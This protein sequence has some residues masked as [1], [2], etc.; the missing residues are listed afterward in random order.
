MLLTG[1][2]RSV[3]ARPRRPGRGVRGRSAAAGSMPWCLNDRNNWVS[4]YL[5][6]RKASDREIAGNL[7][8]SIPEKFMSQ[9]LSDTGTSI[10]NTLFRL[11]CSTATDSAAV[12]T[13]E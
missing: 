1:F 11:A 5:T 8:E 10:N 2:G 7:E 9:V 6:S 4:R 12:V 13:A 3:R